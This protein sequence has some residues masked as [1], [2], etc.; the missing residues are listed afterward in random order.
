MMMMMMMMMMIIIIIII[1][2]VAVGFGVGVND[3]LLT[4][5]STYIK[6]VIYNLKTSHHSR[7]YKMLTCKQCIWN[8]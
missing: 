7:I 3:F 4:A 2:T 5:V 8:L 1:I 6:F